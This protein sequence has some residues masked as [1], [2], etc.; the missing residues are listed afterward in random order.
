MTENV[1]IRVTRLEEHAKYGIKEIAEIKT[2][3]RSHMEAEVKRT[4]DIRDHIKLL[5]ANTAAVKF[6]WKVLATIGIIFISIGGLL[7]RMNGVLP[8]QNLR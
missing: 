7:L 2:M 8:W 1:E 4:D 5:E 3:L 6:G